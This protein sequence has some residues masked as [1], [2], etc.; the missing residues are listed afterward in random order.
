MNPRKFSHCIDKQSGEDSGFLVRSNALW[1]KFIHN[2]EDKLRES[3][4]RVRF[5]MAESIGLQ[6]QVMEWGSDRSME[7]YVFDYNCMLN[8]EGKKLSP[9]DCVF[10]PQLSV[11]KDALP[12]LK[13]IK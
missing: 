7:R 10:F 12:L 9:I 8:H 6:D 2:Q 4:N 5:I 1:T 13:A 3:G 11:K